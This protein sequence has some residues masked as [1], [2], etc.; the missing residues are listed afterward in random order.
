RHHHPA[1]TNRHEIWF[2]P[3][4]LLLQETYGV[5]TIRGRR[6]AGVVREWGG[7]ARILASG[8]SVGNARMLDLA[9]SHVATSSRM[10]CSPAT[11]PSRLPRAL[12]TGGR[13]GC[14]LASGFQGTLRSACRGV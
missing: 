7:V 13:H 8:L 3:R 14:L 12:S 1:V 2:S 6:P 4:V 9:F 11:S 5:R 10:A